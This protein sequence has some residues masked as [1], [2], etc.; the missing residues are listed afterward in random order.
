MSCLCSDGLAQGFCLN[1]GEITANV[2]KADASG[3]G[4]LYYDNKT[5]SYDGLYSAANASSIISN[6]KANPPLTV[7]AASSGTDAD[8]DYAMF[9][10]QVP[11]LQ[12]EEGKDMI[13]Y[14]PAKLTIFLSQSLE[15]KDGTY[16]GFGINNIPNESDDPKGKVKVRR[17][18][19][20][21]VLMISKSLINSDATDAAASLKLNINSIYVQFTV[22]YD[23][24]GVSKSS[25]VTWNVSLDQ[26]GATPAVHA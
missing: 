11:D 26:V 13:K 10:C 22:S 18:T 19:N 21:Y 17:T 2:S 3:N 15:M 1:W 14:T 5:W 9:A 8:A 23:M 6:G 25:Q 20:T 12:D 16:L 4:P 24:L 7:A